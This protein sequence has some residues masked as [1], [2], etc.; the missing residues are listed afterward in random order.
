L[1]PPGRGSILEIGCGDGRAMLQL[2]SLG[3]A[4][5]GIE[6]DRN[7]EALARTLGLQVHIGTIESFDSNGERFDYII[8]N[9]L[10][11]HI[12]DFESFFESCRALLKEDGTVIFST[13]N[14]DS[15]YRKIFKKRWI[16]WHIPFHQN[17]FTLRSLRLLFQKQKFRITHIHITTPTAWTLH[18][19]HAIRYH[20]QRGIP[21]PYWARKEPAPSVTPSAPERSG[22]LRKV[23]RLMFPWLLFGIQCTNR[24]LDLLRRGDCI[25]LYGKKI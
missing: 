15:I 6:T 10:I 9:Q 17:I 5:K 11:E 21:D 12:I 7:V 4:V 22:M 18:Q 1:L 24:L 3:Y 2:A 8:A 13:P 19:F 14:G 16:N 23:K 25:I 20:A